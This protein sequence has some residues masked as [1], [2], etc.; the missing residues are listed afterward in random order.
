MLNITP[1]I[2]KSIIELNM[3]RENSFLSPEACHSNK[4]VRIDNSNITENDSDNIRPSF[5]HDTDRIIHSLAYSRYI[6]KTQVFSFFQNDH[7]THRVLHVQFVSK[8]ARTIGR[9]LSL[10][11]DLIEAI[12]LGHDLGHTPFGHDG[13]FILN[14]ISIENGAGCFAHNAQSV[15]FLMYIENRGLGLNLSLQTL[16]GILS[17]NGELAQ[18]HYEPDIKKNKERF[19][20][21]YSNCWQIPDF[22]K[23]IR[24][25]TL[26]GCVVRISDII[27]YI[28]RD[29]EDAIKVNMIR[30]DELPG[31]ITSVLGNK[32]SEII[33]SLVVDLI[34]NSYNKKYLA[35]SGEVFNA[36]LELKKFNSKNIYYS[37]LLKKNNKKISNLFHNLYHHLI[38]QLENNTLSSGELK[39]YLDGMDKTYKESNSPQRITIDFIAGMTDNYFIKLCE[40]MI[41]PEKL[42]HKI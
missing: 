12:A 8:I 1:E 26:E 30:R 41:F 32:N 28:G 13:E 9:S 21:E 4:A 18:D 3:K 19:L 40:R 11:E 38:V 33:N 36:M 42:G 29:L 22:T 16:D 39:H 17:H 27:A 6:D 15:R 10:N 37:E 25:M 31:S 7:L 35:F 24:P 34:N 14:A 23:S 5:F 20:Q 2:K